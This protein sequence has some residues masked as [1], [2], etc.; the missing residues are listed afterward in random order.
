M[1]YNG[2]KYRDP[3]APLHEGA[4]AVCGGK[5]S[6]VTGE[7][8]PRRSRLLRELS[9]GR[10][11]R[12]P[13]TPSGKPPVRGAA[14]SADATPEGTSACAVLSVRPVGEG[15]WVE[16]ILSLSA[17]EAGLLCAEDHAKAD[18]GEAFYR[19]ELLLTVE[20]YAALRPARGAVTSEKAASLLEAGRLSRAVRRGMNLLAGSSTSQKGLESKLIS[21]G[22]SRKSAAD[23]AAYLAEEGYIRETDTAALRVEQGLCKGWGPRRIKEDLRA[24]GFSPEATEAALEALKGVDHT[25]RLVAVIRKKYPTIPTD[26]RGREKLIAALMRLGYDAATVKNALNRVK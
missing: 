5:E 14:S 10:G 8:P 22:I 25:R 9:G 24:K 16:V 2:K 18:E 6:N 12:T 7:T 21:K 4:E 15:E 20:Q 19:V 11:D 3:S 23:A 1:A 26:P 13:E 17:E